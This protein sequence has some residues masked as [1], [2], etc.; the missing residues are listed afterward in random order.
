MHRA[1]FDCSASTSVI[2]NLLGCGVPSGTTWHHAPFVFIHIPK[3]SGTSAEILLKEWRNISDS[4][5]WARNTH[6]LER[7]IRPPADDAKLG[8]KSLYIGKR[9]GLAERAIGGP[10]LMAT[11]L[12]EPAE[13]ILSHFNYLRARAR[14]PKLRSTPGLCTVTGRSANLT[15][16]EWYAANWRRM[17]DINDFEVRLLVTEEAEIVRTAESASQQVGGVGG[18]G[19][20]WAPLPRVT[21]AHAG[22]ALDRLKR[23]SLIGLTDEF[24]RSMQTWAAALPGFAS[25]N[26][27]RCGNVGFQACGKADRATIPR[28]LLQRIR[29]ENPGSY[30]LWTA[31]RALFAAQERALGKG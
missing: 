4:R 21:H 27:K 19:C 28:E 11:V 5:R 8:G 16:S 3:A 2:P 31:A 1:K 17:P 20:E 30:V 12:R 10:M 7:I 29:R 9:S 23:M 25:R 6:L 22:R 15:F 18:A 26:V 14:N 13:R 24:E